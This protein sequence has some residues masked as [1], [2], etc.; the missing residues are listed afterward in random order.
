MANKVGEL[1]DYS[2]FTLILTAASWTRTRS[3]VAEQIAKAYGLD[4]FSQI[5]AIRH[6]WSERMM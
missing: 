6:T 3:P 2:V 5:D 1:N 4:S